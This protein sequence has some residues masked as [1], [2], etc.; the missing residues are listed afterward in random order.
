MRALLLLLPLPFASMLSTDGA[1]ALQRDAL[2][3]SHAYSIVRSLC[4]EVGPRP[5]GSPADR[6][7]VAWAT[8]T[9]QGLGLA[10]VHTESVRVTHWERGEGRAELVAPVAQRLAVAALGGRVGT[11][12][13]GVE[14]DVVEAASIA[15]LEKLEPGAV[16]GKI[17]FLDPI[18]RRARDG[19]GYGE[20]VP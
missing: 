4:D 20:A 9:M 14:A 18:M 19:G 7:A 8:R 10:N 3:G 15:E 2:S 12:P 1:A 17:V 16:R 13:A 11:P 6:A 5:A